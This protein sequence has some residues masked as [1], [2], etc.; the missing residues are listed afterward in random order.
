MKFR[1]PLFTALLGASFMFLSSLAHAD[2]ITNAPVAKAQGATSYVSGGITIDERD[3]MKP[4]AKDYNLRMMFALNVGN[5]L[6]DVK[7]RIMRGKTTMLDVVTEG[8]WLYVK[9]PAGKYVVSA[10]YEGKSINKHAN[11][12][13]KKGASLAFVWPGVKEHYDD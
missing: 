7:V 13:A 1:K 9:L 2:D 8:P 6:S 4:M 5:Y 10:E 12:S 11:I 3:A